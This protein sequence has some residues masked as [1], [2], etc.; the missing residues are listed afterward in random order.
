V[1]GF[2]RPALPRRQEAKVLHQWNPGRFGPQ[3]KR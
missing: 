2:A 3:S 1:R